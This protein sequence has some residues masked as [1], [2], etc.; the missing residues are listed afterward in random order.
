MMKTET[1]TGTTCPYDGAYITD[2][3]CRE[4][5][6]FELGDEY[7]TCGTCGEAVIWLLYV[8]G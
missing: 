4:I 1:C 2:C 5:I 3:T 6:T 8:E 7:P